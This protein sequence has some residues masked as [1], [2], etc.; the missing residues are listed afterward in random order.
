MSGEKRCGIKPGPRNSF[1]GSR[2]MAKTLI[3]TSQVNFLHT[4]F[5]LIVVIETF[6][7]NLP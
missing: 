3:M 2:L 5:L 4:K 7:I 6:A 1:D